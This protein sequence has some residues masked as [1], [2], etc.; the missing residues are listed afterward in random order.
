MLYAFPCQLGLFHLQNIKEAALPQSD[1][2]HDYSIILDFQINTD[3]NI[4]FNPVNISI[5]G[6]CWYIG[7]ASLEMAFTIACDGLTICCHSD[8]NCLYVILQ[9]EAHGEIIEGFWAAPNG[10]MPLVEWVEEKPSKLD[11]FLLKTSFH[12]LLW[13]TFVTF[14]IHWPLF[15]AA[16][17]LSRCWSCFICSGLMYEI[18]SGGDP[19]YVH[20]LHVCY[21]M[22]AAQF[23]VMSLHTVTFLMTD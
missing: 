19:P 17:S 7:G 11:G 3:F 16:S 13:F 15:P 12:C 22:I 20:I 5:W 23:A 8:R 10:W 2:L 4:L 18:Y 1:P 14:F 9:K 21:C 6:F